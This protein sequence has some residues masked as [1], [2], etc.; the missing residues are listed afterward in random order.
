M[1]LRYETLLTL[2]V[3][4]TYYT[5]VCPDFRFVL[6]ADSER[7]LA[8]GRMLARLRD[9]RL[10][11][12]HAARPDGTPESDQ[13]GHRLRI[14]L[15]LANPLFSNY[16][17][18]AGGGATPLYRNRTTPGALAP[19]LAVAMVGGDFSH[20]LT[21]SER[22]VTVHLRDTAGTVLRSDTVT[23]A[24]GLGAVSYRMGGKDA[25]LY[26]VEEVYAGA[27]GGSL[28]YYDRELARDLFALVEIDIAAA[29]YA[30]PPSFTVTFAAA[31]TPLR[32]YVVTRNYT[33]QEFNQL[34]V[35]DAGFNEDHRPRVQF[36][37]VEAAAF[38]SAE[39]PAAPLA[40][41]G[42]RVVLF[43]SRGPLV[44][45]DKPRRR[46]ELRRSSEVLVSHLPQPGP[47]QAAADMIVHL[48]KP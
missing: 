1:I 40:A 11:L 21:D 14:A 39:L 8:R 41:A 34:N 13:S 26:R 37:R 33:N 16:T 18:F 36:D 44:R 2:G 46:I 35:V 30:T 15:V 24:S 6:P 43:R 7:L 17:D 38:T 22:P 3:S 23:A 4:H 25:G 19:P 32:Y 48:S 29:F 31:S 10:H 27:S 9:G 12:L 42:E 28:Y 47:G 20:A 5:G 45:Q